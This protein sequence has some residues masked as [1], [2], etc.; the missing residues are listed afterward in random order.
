MERGT[1]RRGFPRFPL[2]LLVDAE[3]QR[4]LV[5]EWGN[6][7]EW[8]EVGLVIGYDRRLFGGRGAGT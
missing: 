3:S 1:E 2:A 8:G 5:R 7:R 6:G 4:E